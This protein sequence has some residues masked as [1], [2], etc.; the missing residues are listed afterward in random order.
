MRYVHKL[1]LVESSSS[2]THTHGWRFPPQPKRDRQGDVTEHHPAIPTNVMASRFFFTFHRSAEN[3]P[4][5]ATL[6]ISDPIQWLAGWQGGRAAGYPAWWEITRSL[7]T[8][9]SLL[10]GAGSHVEGGNH[11]VFDVRKLKLVIIYS[12]PHSRKHCIRVNK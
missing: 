10:P 1:F 5:W 2:L 4:Y 7:R 11:K 3:C 8:H 12:I 6:S 9:T